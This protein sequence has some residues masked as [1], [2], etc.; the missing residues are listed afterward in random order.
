MMTYRQQSLIKWASLLAIVLALG[1]G[2]VFA[3]S[4]P[5][6]GGNEQ[7]EAVNGAVTIP[8][9]DVSDGKAHYYRFADGGREIVFFVVKGSDGAFHVAF[10]ACDAC[11]REKKGYAQDG[12][13]MVCRN[14]NMKFAINRIGEANKGG[15]NPAHLDF[16]VAGNNLVIKAADLKAGA[17]FF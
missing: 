10:D 12:K 8:V 13:V 4:F 7:V 15:C 14:C 9:G 5:G 16:A 6:F 17:R 2:S 3:F 11:Y 1:A